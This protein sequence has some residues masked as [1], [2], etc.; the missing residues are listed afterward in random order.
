MKG[1]AAIARKYNCHIQSHISECCGEVNFSRHL[2]PEHR[3]DAH[4]FDEAGLLTNKVC[5]CMKGRPRF[6]PGE[7]HHLPA[8]M[9]TWNNVSPVHV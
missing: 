2:H 6:M 3:C 8:D 9:F 4:V 1:L 7:A 5:A